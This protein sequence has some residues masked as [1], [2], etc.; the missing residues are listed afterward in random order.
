MN[1]PLIILMLIIIR[2]VFVNI[3][4]ECLIHCFMINVCL[5]CC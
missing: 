1:E 4:F 3:M 2:F 5:V